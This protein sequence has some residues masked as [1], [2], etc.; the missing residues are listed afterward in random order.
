ME[1]DTL[2]EPLISNR[3]PDDR[4]DV[5]DDDDDDVVRD[6]VPTSAA[7]A[8]QNADGSSPGLFMWLLTLSAGI[9]GL[10]FGCK[11]CTSVS[12]T[13]PRSLMLGPILKRACFASPSQ[14]I[15]A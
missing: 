13:N 12:S 1:M 11:A 8:S 10:L 4:E 14:M 9:S 2:Q 6:R 5:L 7:T 15:P 3:D